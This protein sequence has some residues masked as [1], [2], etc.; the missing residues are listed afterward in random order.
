MNFEAALVQE[1]GVIAALGGRIYPLDAPETPYDLT[2]PYLI[3][4]SSE[5]LRTKT[6]DGYQIGRLVQGEINVIAPRYSDVKSITGAVLDVFVGMEQR[7]IGTGGPFI[8]E[9]IYR[10]PVEL[11]EDAP[12]LYRCNIEF[13]VYF[14][15]GG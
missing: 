11:Y 13:E 1:L 10:Q 8:Q 15:Q 4:A 14:D 12:K 3:Y 9:V 6:L 5:G 7:V 2:Q